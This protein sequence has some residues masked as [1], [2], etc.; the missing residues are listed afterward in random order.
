MRWLCSATV[1]GERY[2]MSGTERGRAAT[3]LQAFMGY[4]H[5]VFAS[6]GGAKSAV[7][8]KAGVELL[9]RPMKI[10]YAE[11]ANGG[12]GSKDSEGG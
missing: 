1:L 7:E 10:D 12:G 4:A 6:P 2:A 11:S 8:S 5:V 9:G 3:R